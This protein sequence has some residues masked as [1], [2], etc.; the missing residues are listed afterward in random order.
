MGIF[1]GKHP[2]NTTSLL[3]AHRWKA[4]AIAIISDGCTHETTAVYSFQK[5]LLLSL[6]H[7]Q[8]PT[9]EYC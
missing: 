5:V 6:T 3:C 4:R 7:D 9:H 2:D 1:L 8:Q